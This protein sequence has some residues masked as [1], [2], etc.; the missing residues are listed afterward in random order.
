VGV[1]TALDRQ[2]PDIAQ[3]VEH[4]REKR[5]GD[6]TADAYDQAGAGDRG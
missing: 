6:A 4:S 1:I 2:S 3:G 5:S